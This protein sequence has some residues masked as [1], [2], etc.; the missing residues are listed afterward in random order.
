L[1]S[2]LLFGFLLSLLIEI[3]A[4]FHFYSSAVV[5]IFIL[6]SILLFSG[7]IGFLL[8]RRAS[9]S[10]LIEYKSVI[11]LGAGNVILEL[12]NYLDHHPMLEY[13][14]HGFFEDSSL[15]VNSLEPALGTLDSWLAY[16][17]ENRI[18][19]VFCV[20]PDEAIEKIHQLMRQADQE[21][22]RF[23]MVPDVKDYFRKN[24]KVQWLGHMPVLSARTR[25]WRS[26]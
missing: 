25:L 4:D 19:E 8:W 3:V 21:M 7:K 18:Q 15:P 22:I 26:N 13:K 24:V 12:R 14:V 6:F 20:L 1:E 11:I 17:K 23:K 10:R 5:L 9:R 2:L 16:A